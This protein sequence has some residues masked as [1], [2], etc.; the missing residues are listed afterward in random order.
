M[1]PSLQ[2]KA[3]A[4]LDKKGIGFLFMCIARWLLNDG[5]GPP[6][7]QQILSCFPATLCSQQ[8]SQTLRGYLASQQLSQTCIG[9]FD[10]GGTHQF[11][12]PSNGS[13]DSHGAQQLNNSVSGPLDGDDTVQ[14]I[15]SLK[16][17]PMATVRSIS[18]VLSVAMGRYSSSVPSAVRSS[19]TLP[20]TSQRPLPSG[21]YWS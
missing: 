3:A 4:T 18:A 8:P 10:G 21:H 11:I 2:L 9:S 12:G 16:G 17:S 13:F 6:T 1:M 15:G 14:L 5:Y 20:T 19:S 7:S